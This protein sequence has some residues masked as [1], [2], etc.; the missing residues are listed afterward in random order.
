MLNVVDPNDNSHIVRIRDS[1]KYKG[2]V[3]N[4][5]ELGHHFPTIVKE[6]KEPLSVSDLRFIAI[7]LVTALAFLRNCDVI[8]SDVKMES[9]LVTRT[10]ITSFSTVQGIYFVVHGR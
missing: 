9:I 8:H 4:I 5:L 6:T 3:L 2:H 7:Q 1:F 10:N